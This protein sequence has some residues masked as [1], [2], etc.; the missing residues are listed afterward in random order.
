MY[1]AKCTKKT[2]ALPLGNIM[3]L[4][5][6][7]FRERE[8]ESHWRDSMALLISASRHQKLLTAKRLAF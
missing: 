7:S 5:I 3:T 6:W 4:E 8:C 2:L 1:L